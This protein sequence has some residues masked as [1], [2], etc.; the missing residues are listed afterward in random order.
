MR[1]IGF[2]N[3]NRMMAKPAGWDE[4]QRPIHG[5]CLGLPT[6]FVGGVHYSIWQP[7]RWQRL[8]LLLGWKVVLSVVGGQPPVN[9]G[10]TKLRG[11]NN[12]EA[13]E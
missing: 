7:T 6:L 4:H 12:L 9:I 11:S 5:E 2:A 3:A 1:P 8:R 13:I 10:I